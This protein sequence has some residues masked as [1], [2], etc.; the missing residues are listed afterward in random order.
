ME[1]G[2][3]HQD[4]NEIIV[5][6]QVLKQV[7]DELIPAKQ[8][9]GIA[10]RADATWKPRMVV[11]AVLFL[12]TSGEKTLSRGFT[13]CRKVV[14][15]IFRW[16]SPPG[17]SYQ[18][19]VK[20]L[21]KWHEELKWAVVIHLHALMQEQLSEQWTIGG[22]V[23]IAGD[24]SRVELARTRSLEAAFSP[25]RK[26]ASGAKPRR[27]A[28]RRKGRQKTRAAKKVKAQS[29]QSIQ[30]KSNSPQMWLTLFW[31]VGS[32]LP[33]DWRTGPSDSSERS[34]LEEMLS[35]LP[36]NTLIPA[37]AGFVGYEFWSRVLKAGH[38]FLVRVGSNVRFIKHLGF[39]RQHAHT[40]YLWPDSQ[41]QKHRPPLVLRLITVHDGRQPMFLVTDLPKSQLSDRQAVEIYKARWGIEL[42]F[43]TFK[44]TF[45][46]RKLRSHS[47]SNA[48]WELDWSLIGLWC[49]CLWGE[50]ELARSGQ[51]PT[52]L[53]AAKAIAAFQDTLRHYR[54]RADNPT[55]T[56]SPRLKAA[57]LD[58]YERTSRKA[59]RNYPRKKKRERTGPPKMTKATKKQ[60][61]AAMQL[62]KT[63][64][65]KR[66]TA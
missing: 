16:Q 56:L 51:D 38:H 25:K 14:A 63:A 10:C 36:E 47:A 59:S 41:A 18:G 49:V 43:R 5:N 46:C 3:S 50:L 39:A 28:A 26:R 54:V 44:H 15:K 66:L 55:D 45:G 13:F 19:F 17:D 58:E 53:S 40:V 48:T 2:M 23:V 31:H 35:G 34:H 57:L 21:K 61:Q 9:R 20:Q 7:V 30:K 52:Q 22:F 32:G 33:W 6:H 64:S 12:L 62:K 42:F 4:G 60:V 29:A 1:W 24:G 65:E 8:F 27:K 11:V 37:D